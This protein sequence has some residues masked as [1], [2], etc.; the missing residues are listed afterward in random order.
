MNVI[1]KQTCAVLIWDHPRC[2]LTTGMEEG[3]LT[4]L[5]VPR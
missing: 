5:T 4:T 2:T 3:Y 1:H